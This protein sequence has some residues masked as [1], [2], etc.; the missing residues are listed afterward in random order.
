MKIQRME[1]LVLPGKEGGDFVEHG[2]FEQCSEEEYAWLKT[3]FVSFQMARNC[4]YKG[5]KTWTSI[6]CLEK[7]KELNVSDE[8]G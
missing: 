2:V 5:F 1:W 4:K 3:G 7:T 8:A 6:V